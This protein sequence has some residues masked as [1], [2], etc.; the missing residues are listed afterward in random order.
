MSTC[1]LLPTS[2][3]NMN[4]KDLHFQCLD[5][6]LSKIMWHQIAVRNHLQ[7]IFASKPLFWK[8]SKTETVVLR[9]EKIQLSFFKPYKKTSYLTTY[10][11]SEKKNNN[12]LRCQ[13]NQMNERILAKKIKRYSCQKNVARIKLKIS[14]LVSSLS[15]IEKK[16]TFLCMESSKN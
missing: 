10:R 12:I 4:I 8:L 16:R 2:P 14:V 9:P 3:Q 1:T 11:F 5:Y 6:Y 13:L 7:A 15:R